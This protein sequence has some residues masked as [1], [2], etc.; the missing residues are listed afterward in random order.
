MPYWGILRVYFPFNL[1]N[2]ILLPALLVY[3]FQEKCETKYET[4]YDTQCHTEY[5]TE[6]ETIYEEKCEQKYVDKV[7]SLKM[8]KFLTINGF[9]VRQSMSNNVRQSMRPLMSS[10][11][12]HH[13][14]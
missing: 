10:S 14:R 13:M 9:S 8:Y 11:V 12:R 3:N 5:R 1:Q 7:K 2:F 4:Q 6:Y